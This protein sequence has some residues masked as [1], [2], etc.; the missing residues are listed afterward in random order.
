MVQNARNPIVYVL[1]HA[2]PSTGQWQVRHLLSGDVI[3]LD[4]GRLGLQ[5]KA[6]EQHVANGSDLPP[7]IHGAKR[8]ARAAALLERHVV[9]RYHVIDAS[10]GKA[11]PVRGGTETKVDAANADRRTVDPGREGAHLERRI[12]SLDEAGT[13]APGQQA[14][15]PSGSVPQFQ[16]ELGAPR[17][18]LSCHGVRRCGADGHG[19][20]VGATCVCRPIAQPAR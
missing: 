2:D 6:V 16:P 17:G 20:R 12:D 18:I 14:D 10:I 15:P 11:G 9:D 4:A 1:I 7:L 5:W 19:L 13:R 8:P 3:T